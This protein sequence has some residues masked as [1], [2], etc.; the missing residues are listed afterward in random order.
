MLRQFIA[1]LY[2]R[3]PPKLVVTVQD[4]TQLREE[5]AQYN[6]VIQ[7]VQQLQDRLV[8]LESQ[9]GKLNDAQGFINLPKGSFKLER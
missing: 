5:V 6:L 1:W 4:Y 9:V 2:R 7:G 8:R 3:F